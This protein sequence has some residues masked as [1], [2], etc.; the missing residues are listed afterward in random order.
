MENKKNEIV[1]TITI[2]GIYGECEYKYFSTLPTTTGMINRLTQPNRLGVNDDLKYSYSYHTEKY[3]TGDVI[4]SMSSNQDI[5]GLP[6]WLTPDE[7]YRMCKLQQEQMRFEANVRLA[8][9][10]V[11]DNGAVLISEK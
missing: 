2:K 5:I 7:Y 1:T 3:K 8:G 11:Y 10:T 6:R 9:A 4:S